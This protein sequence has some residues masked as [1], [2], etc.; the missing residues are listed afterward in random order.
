MT[1]PTSKRSALTRFLDMIEKAG[2][3]LPDPAI[4]QPYA[5]YM[6]AI[7]HLLNIHIQRN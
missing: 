2:N 7:G 4:F 1:E 6:G 3:K 5:G